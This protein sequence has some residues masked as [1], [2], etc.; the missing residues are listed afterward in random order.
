MISYDFILQH[1]KFLKPSEIK[2]FLAGEGLTIDGPF[3]VVYDPFSGT[4]SLGRDTNNN[5]M[6]TISR[7]ASPVS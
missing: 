4:W 3:G 6:M 1:K 5:Y 2:G 7:P